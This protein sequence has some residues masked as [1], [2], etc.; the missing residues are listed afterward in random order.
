MQGDRCWAQ[1][2]APGVHAASTGGANC[3]RTVDTRFELWAEPGSCASGRV[4]G[5]GGK[6]GNG[7]GGRTQQE[8][9]NC[10]EMLTDLCADLPWGLNKGHPT[11]VIPRVAKP[12]NRMGKSSARTAFVKALVREVVGF[13][14]YERRVMELIRNSKDKKARSA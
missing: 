5:G 3:G 12:S 2:S 6:S 13:A 1:G 4:S 8:R 9:A 10:R 11:T 7:V 14:P